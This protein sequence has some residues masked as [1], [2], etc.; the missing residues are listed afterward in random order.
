MAQLLLRYGASVDALRSGD[1]SPLHYA[2]GCRIASQQVPLV[3]LL[4]QNGTDVNAASAIGTP[5]IM[6]AYNQSTQLVRLLLQAGADVNAVTPAD[7]PVPYVRS[8]TA[9]AAAVKAQHAEIVGLLLAAGA[10]PLLPVSNGCTPFLLAVAMGYSAVV[11]RGKEDVLALL[12]PRLPASGPGSLNDAGSESGAASLNLAVMENH[13]GVVQQLLAAGAQVD[14]LHSGSATALHIAAAM[15]KEKIVQLLLKAG[16]STEIQNCAGMTPLYVVSSPCRH[17]NCDG[18]G[19]EARRQIMALL[20]SRGA[21]AD[22]WAA[23]ERDAST[24]DQQQQQQQQQRVP[25]SAEERQRV[26][27]LARELAAQRRKQGRVASKGRNKRL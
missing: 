13:A 6:A 27:Q 20:L 9:L 24:R 17:P 23:Q 11:Q 3:Q 15:G 1:M 18:S 21:C 8:C 4:L 12:L 5:L 7:S 19:P 16:A 2:I 25:V 22:P 26:Q 14:A 10:D